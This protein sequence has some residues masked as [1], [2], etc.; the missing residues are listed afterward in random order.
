MGRKATE[1]ELRELTKKAA[2]AAIK[3]LT[4]K[5]KKEAEQIIEERARK[6]RSNNK[7]VIAYEV[8]SWA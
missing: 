2:D 1:K 3:P 7:S 4:S 5:T 8:V 6:L